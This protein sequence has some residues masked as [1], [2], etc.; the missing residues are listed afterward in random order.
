M[1]P[2]GYQ[3][4]NAQLAC[5][6]MLDEEDRE[7]SYAI[8]RPGIPVQIGMFSSGTC[9]CVDHDDYVYALEGWVIGEE[10]L[11]YCTADDSSR[12]ATWE[13]NKQDKDATKA[14]ELPFLDSSDN[15]SKKHGKDATKAFDLPHV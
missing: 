14:S 11:S 5:V 3:I 1:K 6:V 9:E 13:S 15:T 8:S 4:V 2:G 10:T 12:S 7:F